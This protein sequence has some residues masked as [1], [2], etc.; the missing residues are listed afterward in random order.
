MP[1]G[2]RRHL[3]DKTPRET[4]FYCDLAEMRFAGKLVDIFVNNGL[5]FS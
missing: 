1:A 4:F 5:N 3:A 2:F